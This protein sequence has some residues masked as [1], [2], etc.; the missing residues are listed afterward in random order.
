MQY[1]ILYYTILYY[2][3]S[4]H[5]TLYCTSSSAI[6]LK[7]VCLPVVATIQYGNSDSNH[8]EIWGPPLR[9][10]LKYGLNKV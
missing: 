10:P 9:E 4:Y 3:I 6:A 2:T 5:V 1:N 8:W 7:A